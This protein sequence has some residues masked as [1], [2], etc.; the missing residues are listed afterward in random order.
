ML[1]PRSARSHASAAS[2][3]SQKAQIF[4]F[5]LVEGRADRGCRHVRYGESWE[6]AGPLKCLSRD[7]RDVESATDE[8][9]TEAV[10][11]RVAVVSYVVGGRSLGRSAGGWGGGRGPS[12]TVP[13][14]RCAVPRVGRLLLSVSANVVPTFARDAVANVVRTFLRDA[15]VNVVRT[16]L[17]DA[18]ANIIRK[19]LRDG[20]PEMCHCFRLSSV[21]H[22]G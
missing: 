7:R 21:L 5:M 2:G 6:D 4:I 20:L 17:R 22:S 14:T 12:D 3:D 19:F 11:P 18:L 16:F 15:V 8:A 9:R 13:L 1:I 10:S